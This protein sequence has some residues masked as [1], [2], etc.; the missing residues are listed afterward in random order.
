[1]TRIVVEI[2]A[3]LLAA[4][5]TGLRVVVKAADFP[6]ILCCETNRHCERIAVRCATASFAPKLLVPLSLDDARPK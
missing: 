4:D 5:A 2:A 1:V 3:P 6:T